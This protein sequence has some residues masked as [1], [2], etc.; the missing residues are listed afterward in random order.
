VFRKPSF[1]NPQPALDTRGAVAYI[2]PTM[3]SG[4]HNQSRQTALGG[5]A[6][7]VAPALLFVAVL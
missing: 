2:E 3:A 5:G 7:A 4:R 1:W 6:M